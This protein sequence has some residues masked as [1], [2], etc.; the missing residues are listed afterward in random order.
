[1]PE[2]RERGNVKKL[3]GTNNPDY[4]PDYTADSIKDIDFQLLAKQ[5]I[6]YVALD[7]DNTLVPNFGITLD[8]GDRAILRKNLKLFKQSWIA[9]NRFILN[10][11]PLADSIGVSLFQATLLTRKPQRRYYTQLLKKMNASPKEVVMIGD[12]L[13]ADIWGANRVGLKTVLVKPAGHDFILTSLIQLRA[14]ERYL[15]KKYL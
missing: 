8:K 12:S 1:M 3:S 9:T 14:V 2:T 10:L 11:E 15:L 6:K 13:W 5:G 7:V 4:V